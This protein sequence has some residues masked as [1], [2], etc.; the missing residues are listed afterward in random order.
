[1]SSPAIPPAE[2]RRFSAD[3]AAEGPRFAVPRGGAGLFLPSVQITLV[4]AASG[5]ACF[6]WAVRLTPASKVFTQPLPPLWAILVNVALATAIAIATGRRPGSPIAR[7]WPA[8]LWVLALE[9][10]GYALYTTREVGWGALLAA[11]WQAGTAGRPADTWKDPTWQALVVACFAALVPLLLRLWPLRVNSRWV[12]RMGILAVLSLLWLPPAAA[13]LQKWTL[14]E[15]ARAID[16]AV[17]GLDRSREEIDEARGTPRKPVDMKKLAGISPGGAINKAETW[18]AAEVIGQTG[19]LVEAR[20][21]VAEAVAQLRAKV[22]CP[23]PPPAI[24]SPRPLQRPTF[25]MFIA[26]GSIA[27]YLEQTEDSDAH[28][29]AEK[30][31]ADAQ[32]LEVARLCQALKPP[33]GVAA[34][35]LPCEL[36]EEDAVCPTA[37]AR[38]AS[39]ARVAIRLQDIAAEATAHPT[40]NAAFFQALL[41]KTR[42]DLVKAGC[43]PVAPWDFALILYCNVY[44]PRDPNAPGDQWGRR[45]RLQSWAAF[46]AGNPSEIADSSRP[47]QL[48]VTLSTSKG[49]P[50]HGSV[51]D[52]FKGLSEPASYDR[53]NCQVGSCFLVEFGTDRIQVERHR[54]QES[55][56]VLQL[57]ARLVPGNRR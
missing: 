42:G 4:S 43:Y 41:G 49:Q 36:A 7:L 25:G 13:G 34:E 14:A 51:F 6:L 33:K 18:R 23:A 44:A 32:L 53:E 20:G 5:V 37:P 22:Q 47:S 1:M 8:A 19:R 10:L 39:G 29:A 56:G 38:T 35:P 26:D 30:A 50:I 54:G 12:R 28:F 57:R 24:E 52:G 3:G 27:D 45:V 55:R 40:L 46:Q 21:R 16:A 9:L 2:I 15:S 48:F 31:S 17:E 11:P